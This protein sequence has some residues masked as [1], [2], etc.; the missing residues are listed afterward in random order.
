ML[1]PC[2]RD[3]AYAY[4]QACG[5]TASACKSPPRSPVIDSADVD[6]LTLNWYFGRGEWLDYT[7]SLG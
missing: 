6:M 2:E 7:C 5:G 1:A 4:L 3:S